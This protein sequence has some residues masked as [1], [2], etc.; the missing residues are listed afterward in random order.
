VLSREQHAYL[1]CRSR[2]IILSR[3]FDIDGVE[4]WILFDT[5]MMKRWAYEMYMMSRYHSFGFR[6]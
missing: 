3:I 6:A 2:V 5:L 4:R 1:E